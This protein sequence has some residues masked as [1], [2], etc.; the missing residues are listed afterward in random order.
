MLGSVYRIS[1]RKII[2]ATFFG[3][4]LLRLVTTYYMG[5]M[6]QDAYYYYY[7]D[8]LSLSYFDHPFGVALMLKI[9][10][11][12]F[13]KSVWLIKLTDF[14]VSLFSFI[15][16]YYLSSLVLNRKGAEYVTLLFGST[17][18]LT[19]LSINTTPDVP[20]VFF[21]ILTLIAL[22]NA[23]FKGNW[24]YWALSGVL[25][26]LSVDSKYTGIFLLAGI[27]IFL[28]L[29]KPNRHMILSWKMLLLVTLFL[30]TISPVIYWNFQH[31]WISLKYQSSQRMHD[32]SGLRI[33]PEYF[34]GN[35]GL[36][37]LLLLPTLFI[38]MV[39]GFI[40]AMIKLFD[41]NRT[42]DQKILFLLAFSL[43]MILFFFLI[44]PIYWVKMNWIMP[45]YATGIILIGYLANAKK[46]MGYHMILSFIFHIVLLVEVS[47]HVV[48][49]RSD[50]TWYGWKELS[51]KVEVLMKEYDQSYFIF[52]NDEYK[53][54]A[55]LK[56][57]MNGN[58]IYSGHILGE[59]G[60]QFTLNEMDLQK[61]KGQNAIFIDSDKNLDKEDVK[62]KY[63]DL[64]NTYF[65][66]VKR[67]SPI[68]IN[69]EEGR[70]LRKFL[71]YECRNYDPS[72]LPAL[73]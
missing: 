12:L 39:A 34:F 1:W 30:V 2:L 40:K 37:M 53:T 21:W 19:V 46:W 71:I 17:L 8:N 52:S 10:T 35:L 18:L 62:S 48:N 25:M 9:S 64:L 15:G 49:V 44:S 50:D 13:G 31:D 38:A 59:K 45:A 68:I 57:F 22:Y 6:P 43:P 51:D 72:L 5:I 27:F 23:F 11:W 7:S 54:T 47:T 70:H 42:K 20:L 28:M 61:M 24:H 69:D 58:R 4:Y 3:I 56:F 26:G 32:M 65:D 33:R 14:T 63:E 41:R 67:L 73:D 66:S 36:Q 16:F 60:F 29:S 55:V